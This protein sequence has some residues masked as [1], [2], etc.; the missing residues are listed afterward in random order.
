MA[1]S[2]ALKYFSLAVLLFCSGTVFPQIKHV[3]ILNSY[4]QGF[5]WNDSIS[6]GIRQG[7]GSELKK[8]DIQYEYMDYK[9]VQGNR[10]LE[11]YRQ[12]LENKLA[13]RSFDVVIVTDNAAL[14]FALTHFRTFLGSTPIV[15]CGIN[16][17]SP[18]ILH[19]YRNITGVAE[20][21]DVTETID[22]ILKL[23]PGIN[24]I[25]VINDSSDTSV[26]NTM[27]FDK[28]V[29]RYKN[30]IRV[31]YLSDMRIGRL[32][33][34]IKKL[35][36]NSA[37]L[38]IGFIYDENGLILPITTSF[39]DVSLF[40]HVPMY[41]VWDFLIGNGI[42]GGMVTT[43]L[44]QG[45]K[46]G[47]MTY[48]ILHGQKA[49]DIPVELKSPNRYMFDY[50]V[51]ERFS[52]KESQLPPGSVVINRPRQFY[53]VSV[54]AVWIAFLVFICLILLIIALFIYISAKKK[55]ERELVRAKQLAERSDNLKSEF[56]A[57]M[58][59]EIRTPINSILSFTSLIKEQVEDKVDDDLA[60]GFSIINRA[61]YRII[62]TINL[63]LNMSEIQTDN[64]SP[65]FRKI[66]LYAVLEKINRDICNAA[67]ER[68]NVIT[69]HKNAES[70]AV[71]AD[72]YSAVQ[73]FENLLDNAVKYTD[74]GS[75]DIAVSKKGAGLA[76]EIA[77]TGVG[78][79]ED[80]LPHLFKLFRQE[81]QGYTRR[82]EGNGLGLVLVKKYCELN[83]I[84]IA[85][86]SQKGVGTK[87][88]LILPVP[89]Y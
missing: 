56:L 4:H 37:I 50:D 43:G 20:E 19:G 14:N 10:Y 62:R 78:I 57:Q 82:F 84:D 49:S 23:Q 29:A 55:I 27:N 7:L 26:L 81:E 11:N 8:L 67:S 83:K 48:R 12:L 41:A 28:A 61:G 9:R 3:L 59:H 71:F 17:F 53:S 80:Y 51:L 44:E 87:F 68:Q 47:E 35:P 60:S 25:A 54:T 63:L 34:E 6:E 24:T 40:S 1:N 85:V 13:G 74:H 2:R 30:F 89:S 5:A 76:V 36:E 22:V 21:N 42:M 46:V 38:A 86:E 64:Y 45:R 33:S 75:I 15:F 79:S 72:E 88:T 31:R 32:K 70:A 16:N 73:I 52:I 58:S 65:V 66:D 69:L 39:P 18:D 77:D